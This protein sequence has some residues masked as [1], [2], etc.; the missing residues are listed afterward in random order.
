MGST[1]LT[2]NID[3]L[4]IDNINNVYNGIQSR[5]FESPI[6]GYFE[7]SAEYESVTYSIYNNG[8]DILNMY[9]E[10]IALCNGLNSLE[11]TIKNNSVHKHYNELIYFYNSESK[12]PT[13]NMGSYIQ[14][15]NSIEVNGIMYSDVLTLNGK[16]INNE[17]IVRL[18]L[19]KKQ[20]IIKMEFIN[21]SI[22]EQWSLLRSNIIQ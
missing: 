12:T 9:F 13:S 19:A 17:F 8:N 20:G 1:I 2:N 6:S 3:C 22:N 7:E 16:D 11:V 15:Y 14:K 5:S 10:L 18:W 21:D 4:Y